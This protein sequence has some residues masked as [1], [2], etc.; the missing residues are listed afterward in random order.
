MSYHITQSIG[1][2]VMSLVPSHLFFKVLI[3]FIISFFMEPSMFFI[4]GNPLKCGEFG[5]QSDAVSILSV[6]VPNFLYFVP[7]SAVFNSPGTQNK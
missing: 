1:E 2:H 5:A 3:D 4:Q 6:L 7:M